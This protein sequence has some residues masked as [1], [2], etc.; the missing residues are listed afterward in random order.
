MSRKQA[1]AFHEKLNWY[2]TLL[3][4]F[5]FVSVPPILC[6]LFYL[7]QVPDVVWARDDQLTFDRIWIYRTRRPAGIGYQSQRVVDTYSP[8]EVCVQ[9]RVHFFL[10]AKA[11][12]V[13][14]ATSRHVVVLNDNRWQSTGQVCP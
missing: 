2:L 1:S 3:V 4:L 9:N 8:T 11:E 14:G 12:E 7:S 6:S 5:L 13:V 10:W